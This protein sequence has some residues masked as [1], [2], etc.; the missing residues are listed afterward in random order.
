MWGTGLGFLRLEEFGVGH[1]LSHSG[2]FAVL[3]QRSRALGTRLLRQGSSRKYL[4][5]KL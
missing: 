3:E 5:R 4:T 1:F 2:S